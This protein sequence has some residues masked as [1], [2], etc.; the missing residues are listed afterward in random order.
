V[1]VVHQVN[2]IWVPAG[3]GGGSAAPQFNVVGQGGANQIAE[4]MANRES[5]PIKAYV[6]GQDVTTSQ[7]L[8]RS[9]VNNATL[10]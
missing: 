3:G 8:N 7:S 2:L 5:Q 4:S 1:V 6:V 10:G 9:I